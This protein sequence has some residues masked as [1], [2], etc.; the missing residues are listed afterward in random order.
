MIV[1]IKSFIVISALAMITFWVAAKALPSFL[2][3]KEYKQWRSSWLA[4]ISIAA[5]AHNIWLFA[6]LVFCYCAFILPEARRSRV[7]YFLLLFSILPMLTV[8]LP[9]VFGIRSLIQLNYPTI[10]IFSILVGLYLNSNQYPRWLSLKSDIFVLAY[11]LVVSYLSFRDDTFTNGLRDSLTIFI[12]FILPYYVISRYLNDIDQL[13]RALMALFIGIAPLASIGIF[14]TLKHWHVYNPIIQALHVQS[15]SAGYDMRSGGLRASVIYSSPIVLGY[16]LVIL[17]GIFLYMRPLIADQRYANLAGTVIIVG[18]LATISRGPWVGMVC[19]FYAYL[20]TGPGG[21]TKIAG[22][23]LA[24]ILLSP[25]LLLTSSGKAFLDLLPFIGSERA[26]TV[27]YRAEL[28]RQS[29]IVFKRNPWFGSTTYLDTP[30]MESMRQGHG[31]IDIVN[32]YVEIALEYGLIGLLF[33]LFIFV[34]LLLRC[35]LILRRIP[36]AEADLLRMGRALFAILTSILL[37]IGTA[38]SIDYVPYFYWL[39]AGI[40]AAYLNVV[41]RTIKKKK[42]PLF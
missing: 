18:L 27:D 19:L 32:T 4:I 38:S 33:F 30:E 12:R 14:E 28:A 16:V 25:L 37:I 23:S 20:W 13:N 36:P 40:A 34:G 1:L 31:I 2:T 6:V 8:E 10:L 42:A 7:M 26:D 21:L 15:S 17:F 41:E 5:I 22:W 3:L 9:G 24:G 35:Y 29:W 39:F 11:F